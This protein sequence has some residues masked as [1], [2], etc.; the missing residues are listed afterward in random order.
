MPRFPAVLEPAAVAAATLL[1]CV[2]RGLHVESGDFPLVDGGMFYAMVR[3]IQANGFGF[4]AFTS[5]NS[6]QIPFAYPPLPFY[7]AAVLSAVT[8]LGIPEVLRVLPLVAS[9]LC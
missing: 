8:P 7:L 6:L 4:P 2:V 1:G 9:C 3:D 5:Y